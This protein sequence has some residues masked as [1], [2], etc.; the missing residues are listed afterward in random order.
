MKPISFFEKGRKGIYNGKTFVNIQ[1]RK[2]L[3]L[4]I[5]PF[6]V[7]KFYILKEKKKKI[8]CGDSFTH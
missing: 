3:F 8:K 5:E 1:P 6:S 4:Y 2:L 7:V